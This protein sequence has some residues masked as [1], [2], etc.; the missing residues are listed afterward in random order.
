MIPP[1]PAWIL[2]RAA[3]LG[4]S[5]NPAAGE[6]L[7]RYGLLVELWSKRMNLMGPAARERFWEDHLAE[8]LWLAGLLPPVEP[9]ADLG[10][11]AGLPGLVLAC[12]EP[13][14]SIHLFEARQKKAR[15]LKL[16]AAQLGLNRVDVFARRVGQEETGPKR[17]LAVSRAAAPLSRLLDLA[18]HLVAREGRL[19]A[20]KGPRYEEELDEAGEALKRGTWT[21]QHTD[22]IELYNKSRIALT[23]SRE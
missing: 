14:R 11:G 23:F 9:L 13:R 5:L 21:L 4:F 2:A 12:L 6:R 7:Y 10:A 1:S 18:A 8:G 19:V 20:L 3:D 22:I 16:A 15:F 17:P